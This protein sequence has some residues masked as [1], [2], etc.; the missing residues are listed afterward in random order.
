MTSLHE[1]KEA[2]L[3]K[4]WIAA[5]DRWAANGKGPLP[6]CPR[7]HNHTMESWDLW[8]VTGETCS[9]CD[10]GSCEGGGCLAQ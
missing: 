9:N 8:L 10:W 1:P 7:C 4:Q 6:P 2:S 5:L 3:E